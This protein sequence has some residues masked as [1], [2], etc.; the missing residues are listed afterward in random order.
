MRSGGT[1]AKAVFS[2]AILMAGPTIALAQELP[3]YLASGKTFFSD[4]RAFVFFADGNAP[5]GSYTLDRSGIYGYEFSCIFVDFKPVIDTSGTGEVCRHIATASCDD[6]SGI[7]RPDVFNLSFY[8]NQITVTS[9]NDH[10]YDLMRQG[11]DGDGES[12]GLVNMQ[13]E[14]C[15]LD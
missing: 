12:W 13:F 6:D 8:E 4:W 10:L 2:A 15:P 5:D 14:T 9:Q 1:F 3:Q 11:E 7:N